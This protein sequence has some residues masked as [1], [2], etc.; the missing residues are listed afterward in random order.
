M[1]QPDLQRSR[2][3][4]R[5]FSITLYAVVA[6]WAAGATDST[7]RTSGGAGIGLAGSSRRGGRSEPDLGGRGAPG[8]VPAR[9]RAG[10]GE[11]TRRAPRSSRSAAPSGRASRSSAASPRTFRIRRCRP[12]PGSPGVEAVSLDGRVIPS[13]SFTSAD[14]NA[15][16]SAAGVDALWG[17]DATPAPATPAIAVIDSGVDATRAWTTSAGASSRR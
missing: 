2:L 8:S 14:P 15:W 5:R 12:W 4:A 13:G 7:G 3:Q 17:T 16:P 11:L 1:R 6:L 10:W 9:D